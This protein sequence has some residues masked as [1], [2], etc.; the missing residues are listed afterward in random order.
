LNQLLKMLFQ[1]HQFLR[2]L[3]LR[4]LLLRHHRHHL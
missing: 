1:R 3:Q 2:Q 4:L